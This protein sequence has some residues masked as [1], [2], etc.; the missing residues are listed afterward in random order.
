VSSSELTIATVIREAT[1]RLAEAGSATPRLDAEVLLR[2]LLGLDRTGLFVRLQEPLSG[3]TQSELATLIARRI[4][5]EP[6][7]F[8][9]GIREFMGLSFVVGPGVLVPRPETELLVEWAA[10]WLSDRAASTVVDVGTGS[11][12]IA[13]SLATLRQGQADS[14]VG[15]DRSVGAM[16]FAAVN[17]ERFGL[18]GVVGLVLGDLVGW[19]RPPIDLVL[20]NLPYLR[21]DQLTSNP[22]L[23]AEPEAALVSG[24]DGLDAIRRLVLDLPRV[25]ASD[26]G[27]GLEIDPSQVNAVREG[28]QMSLPEARIDVLRDLAGLD[29]FVVAGFVTE[30]LGQQNQ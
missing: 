16:Q 24:D 8:L 11:G 12:A 18:T 5:G 14:I 27:V 19:C 4:A 22:D 15:V 30:H 29:R 26:G 13:L 7:A 2:H 1:S 23:R 9:T 3:E 28:L 17:R 10:N 20:A 25:L 21:P 6:V